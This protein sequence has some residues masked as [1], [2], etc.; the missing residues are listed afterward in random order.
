MIVRI[1]LKNYEKS[2]SCLFFTEF[3]PQQRN[4]MIEQ[5]NC[6]IKVQTKGLGDLGGGYKISVAYKAHII[7][8]PMDIIRQL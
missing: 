1:F 6:L 2:N 3:E 7:R 4:N 8:V 5:N